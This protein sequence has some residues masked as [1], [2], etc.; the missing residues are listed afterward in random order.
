MASMH[1]LTCS[2]S[3][4]LERSESQYLGGREYVLIDLW[5]GWRGLRLR[6]PVFV[7]E[8]KGEEGERGRGTL[9][10]G[11]QGDNK[12]EE[13]S[14]KGRNSQEGSLKGGNSHLNVW[15]RMSGSLWAR[16]HAKLVVKAA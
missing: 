6:Y 7:K 10:G 9:Q 2:R 3:R 14:L 8:T 4:R 16:F 5:G 12:K 11:E 1:R 13:G 15:P